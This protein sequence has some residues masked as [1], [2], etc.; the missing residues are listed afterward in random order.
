MEREKKAGGESSISLCCP[1]QGEW[2]H[3]APQCLMLAGISHSGAI[4]AWGLH[5]LGPGALVQTQA[6]GYLYYDL[7]LCWGIFASV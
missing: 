6:V 3:A 4:L 2:R 5:T 7:L 1:A